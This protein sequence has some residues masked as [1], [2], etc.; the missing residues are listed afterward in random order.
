MSARRRR[1]P[2][3]TPQSVGQAGDC[4]EQALLG[5]DPALHDLLWDVWVA[6]PARAHA[7]VAAYRQ[8]AG[9]SAGRATWQQLTK[10]A[11][12]PNGPRG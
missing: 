1:Q 10:R 4:F 8:L 5:V 6:D 11:Q 7:L 9:A 3:R 2:A 12:R